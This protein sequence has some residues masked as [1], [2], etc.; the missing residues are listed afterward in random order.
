MSEALV[1]LIGGRSTEHDASLQSYR[2]VV[3]E[4]LGAPD[5][6]TLTAVVHVDRD[7]GAR[8]LTG[9]RWPVD[10]ADIVAW[11]TVPVIAAAEFLRATDAFV[12]SLLHGTEGEDG[13]WQGVAEVFD[14]RGS[15]GSV[16]GAAL[17]MDKYLQ[18]AVARTTVP[19]LLTPRTEI[20]RRSEVAD[21]VDR[22]LASFTEAD[23]V[24]KPNR[25]GASLLTEHLVD[26]DVADLSKA[27]SSV[28]EFDPDALVQQFISGTEVSC[29]VV[30]E[31]GEPVALPVLAI[32]TTGG[33][34]GHTQKHRH[35]LA[36]IARDTSSAA[37]EIQRISVRL[38]DQLRISG[39]GRFDFILADGR[40]H[41]L[42]VN[43]IPGLMSG[44]LFPRMLRESGRTVVGLIESCVRAADASGP[45]VKRLDYVIEH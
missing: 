19:G 30:V 32:N 40:P 45:A 16:L 33:F 25:M 21:G 22:A 34:F 26:W 8:V 39:W 23:V 36:E 11:P 7:D 10:E 35:G 38:F 29:G 13:C 27:V 28:H 18:A 9:P 6:F 17:G 5:R 44:S 3:T 37:K 4:V 43:T 14:I 31:N 15:F 24:V 12:F 2:H 1:L 42:E 41:F 20:I